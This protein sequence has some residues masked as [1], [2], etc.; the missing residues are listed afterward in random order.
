MWAVNVDSD[1]HEE[2]SAPAP[3]AGDRATPGAVDEATAEELVRSAFAHYDPVALGGAVA[4]TAA[5]CL[6]VATAI[7]LLKGGPRVGLNLSLLGNYLLG[8]DASWR[9]AVTGAAE[10]G[11]GGFAL[12]WVL[13][14]AINLVVGWHEAGLRRRLESTGAMDLFKDGSE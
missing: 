12:G 9:G 5:A 2:V 3:T 14:G 4:I 13:A 1:Y 7:L 11:L 10:A 8:F 6:F